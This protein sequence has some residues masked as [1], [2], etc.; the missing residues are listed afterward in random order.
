MKQNIN[1]WLNGAKSFIATIALICGW[2]VTFSNI[3]P[4]KVVAWAQALM[5]LLTLLHA[6]KAQYGSEVADLAKGVGIDASALK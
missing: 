1:K 6:W 2:I 4:P 3:L 5:G